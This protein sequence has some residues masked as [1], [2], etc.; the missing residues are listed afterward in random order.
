MNF[1]TFKCLMACEFNLNSE[2]P[3]LLKST[4]KYLSANYNILVGVL[5]CNLRLFTLKPNCFDL[6]SRFFKAYAISGTFCFSALL[7]FYAH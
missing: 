4:Y 3:G 5:L 7:S 6:K 1:Q 2:F